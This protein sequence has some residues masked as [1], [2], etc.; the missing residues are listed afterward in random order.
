MPKAINRLPLSW[1]QW[2]KFKPLSSFVCSKKELCF[3]FVVI[4]GRQWSD[5][6]LITVLG[7]IDFSLPQIVQNEI[8]VFFF[9]SISGNYPTIGAWYC[10]VLEGMVF[11]KYWVWATCVQQPG[12]EYNKHTHTHSHVQQTHACVLSSRRWYTPTGPLILSTNA[13]KKDNWTHN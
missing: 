10:S 2:T 5:H 3:M 9:F 7:L 4:V 6:I 12:F 8:L 13:D 1:S 11:V